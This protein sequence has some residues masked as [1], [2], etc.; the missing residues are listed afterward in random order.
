MAIVRLSASRVIGVTAGLTLAGACFGGLAGILVLVVGAATQD[1][2]V[3][4]SPWLYAWGGL[5]G[6]PLG[7][8]CAPIA[9]WLLLREV[10]LG[11]AF[12]VA[13]MGTTVGGLVGLLAAPSS[14][15]GP[16][17]GGAV[18]CVLAAALLRFYTKRRR[19]ALGITRGAA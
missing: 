12:L 9:G 11:R 16:P 3:L 19:T 7:A 13:T 17:V 6:A 15:L 1:W 10:P 8:V 2:K 4:L 18:G 14:F 5:V